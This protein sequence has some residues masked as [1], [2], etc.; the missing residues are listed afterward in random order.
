MMDDE[1]IVQKLF[2]FR[3]SQCAELQRLKRQ[4]MTV[5]ILEDAY[6]RGAR[7]EYV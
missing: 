4:S 6:L 3:R 7:V 2:P 5:G 1:C